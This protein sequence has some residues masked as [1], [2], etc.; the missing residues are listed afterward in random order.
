[1]NRS[2]RALLTSMR[3]LLAATVIAPIVLFGWFAWH[4][5][6]V[7]VRAA[8]DRAGRL[9]AIVQEHGLK[10]FETIGLILDR[11]DQRL[12]GISADE[13]KTS[14]ALWDELKLLV[15]GSEQVGSIFVTT[16]DGGN[17]LTTRHFPPADVS[18]ADRDYF[19]AH[20]RERRGLYVGYGYA[21]KISGD[22]IFNFSIRKSMPHGAFDGVIG[23]SAYVAYFDQFY[24]SLGVPADNFTI[25]LVRDDGNL[26][27]R[28]PV[29]A[30]A[31]TR[32][33]AGPEVLAQLK[34]REKGTFTARSAIDGT[35]RLIGHA[36][37]RNYPVYAVY[38]VDWRAITRDW[39]AGIAF[40]GALA[41][42][43]AIC[44]FLA[45]LMALR[46]LQKQQLAFAAVEASNRKLRGE[47]ERRERAESS[48][49]QAQR[50]EAIGQ[51]TSRIAHDFNNLLMVI[52]GNLD[53]AE[54]R[55]DLDAIRRKFKSIR[56]ATDRART[57]TQQLL[58]FAR[59]HAPDATT[60]DVNAVLTAARSLITYSLPQ[61]VELVIEL[62][63]ERLPVKLAVSEFEAAVLNM[64]GNARDAM[65]DGGRLTLTTA[66]VV[67]GD[68]QPARAELRIADTG[69]GMSPEVVRQIYEP[70]FT[71]KV[72]GKG[73]GLGMSQV[74]GLVQQARGSI[75]IAS[76][77]GQGTCITLRFPLSAEPVTPA[78]PLAP[79]PGEVSRSMTILVVDDHRE[80]RQVTSAMLEDLGHQIL[81][82]RNSAEALALLGTGAAVDVLIADVDLGSGLDG[83]ELGKQAVAIAPGLKV[84]LTTGN[85]GQALLLT[86]NDFAVLAKPY[87]RVDLNAAIIA[88]HSTR[89][90]VLTGVGEVA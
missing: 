87:T 69:C 89:G 77:V 74:Y 42:A 44:L 67:A 1:V 17:A 83:V 51:L 6:G 47:I 14:K 12:T 22:T 4:S 16:A 33:E 90:A 65:P 24:A 21:G 8:E 23:I 40:G 39:L 84:L 55:S 18:F 45:C 5:Y 76:T 28:H 53:L 54:R 34:A 81:V 32:L 64:V 46:N 66:L 15:Q 13:L 29:P 58:G 9:A 86:Q 43:I 79:A 88:L 30:Q 27:V 7:T 26:L 25:V 59:R 68:G 52:S 72:R 20:Q 36:K 71:T 75:S 60:V 48:L 2:S 31:A 62:G 61:N 3:M 82:A 73:T 63:P 10:V 80:V 38:T 49:M 57:L 50:L 70:F 37:L 56:Y 11:V 41:I 85:P 19:I 78:V 35:T